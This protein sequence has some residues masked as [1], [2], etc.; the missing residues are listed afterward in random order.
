MLLKIESISKKRS[1]EFCLGPIDLTL[2]GGTNLVLFGRNGA[3]KST[4]FDLITCNDDADSGFIY[5]NSEK[6]MPQKFQVRK[7]IG[8]LPQEFKLPPWVLPAEILE[9]AA[10]LHQLSNPKEIAEKWMN[11]W[12]CDAFRNRA[13]SQCS[14][15]MQKRVA[16]ALSEI[17]EPDFLVLDEPL[18]G[19]DMEFVAKLEERIEARAAQKKIT[20]LSL[21]SAHFAAKTCS[22]A[23]F[24]EK[25][26]LSEVTDWKSKNIMERIQSI[27]NHF[28]KERK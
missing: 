5:L 18:N 16:L 7:N 9:Y 13:L 10:V 27:E 11:F 17:H 21:H 14:Y 20:V 24:I 4:L 1:Q 25:G 12:G 26:K 19:L 28:A 3:G 8:Y 6:C 2:S 22:D 23:M 15:G